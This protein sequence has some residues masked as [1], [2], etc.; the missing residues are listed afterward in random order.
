[1]FVGALLLS[2]SMGFGTGFQAPTNAALAAEI[3]SLEASCVSF[4]GGAIVM[5]AYALIVNRGKLNSL[6]GVAPWKLTGGLYG[7]FGVLFAVI[8]TP[9]LGVGLTMAT[10]MLGQMTSG[11]IVDAA[12]LLQAKRIPLEK[13]RI[14]GIALTALGVIV[15]CI[16]KG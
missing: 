11:V 4:A 12:G 5:L 6:A 8:A 2:L 3:G 9:V 16:G 13:L 10:T 1:M 15:V 14:A 7:A